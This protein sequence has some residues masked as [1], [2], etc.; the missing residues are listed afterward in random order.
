MRE[1]RVKGNVGYACFGTVLGEA[2][3]VVASMMPNMS[4]QAVSGEE[5]VGVV[6]VKLVT[7][8]ADLNAQIE[9]TVEGGDGL[10][11]DGVQ[12]STKAASPVLGR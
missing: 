11:F 1:A 8:V 2:S 4:P 10:D 3:I 7:V 12:R 5:D 6:V 9:D